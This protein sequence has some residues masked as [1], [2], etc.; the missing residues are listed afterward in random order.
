MLVHLAR[1]SSRRSRPHTLRSTSLLVALVTQSSRLLLRM[2]LTRTMVLRLRKYPSPFLPPVFPKLEPKSSRGRK[3]S[4]TFEITRLMSTQK[5]SSSC[6]Q[7]GSKEDRRKDHCS[8]E[9]WCCFQEGIYEEG[10]CC[11]GQGCCR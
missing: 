11:K 6:C 10:S 7:E 3:R 9:G 4:T 5:A 2:D 1:S 8:K